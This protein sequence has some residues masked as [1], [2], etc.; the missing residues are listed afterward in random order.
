MQTMIGGYANG[1]RASCP[2][3]RDSLSGATSS[4]IWTPGAP[5]PKRGRWSYWPSPNTGGVPQVTVRRAYLRSMGCTSRS[6]R[7]NCPT[8]PA[9]E[10]ILLKPERAEGRLPGILALH[11]H[12]GLKYWGWQKIARP[13][14]QHP[15]IGRAS[16]P[17]L[18][19]RGLGQ[20]DRPARLW[21]CWFPTRSP[22]PA[23]ACAWPM[24][25][26]ASPGVSATT[27]TPITHEHRRL[28]PV[29]LGATSTSWPSRCSALEPPGPAC[30]W[31]RSARAGCALRPDDVDQA[32]VGCGGLSGGGMRTV[33]LAG[34]GR[35]HPL[36]LC[37]WG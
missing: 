25:P 4:P 17:I 33:Y 6:Y 28:Q 7:G 5:R 26:R 32:R 9:T 11:D 12:G 23:A 30:S 2:T 3:R 22:L 18:W 34:L 21:W 27:R 1:R 37:A 10:A 13:R 8:G 35:A 29:G 19:R 16:T 15:L 20:R 31:P 24:F 14:D 36:P